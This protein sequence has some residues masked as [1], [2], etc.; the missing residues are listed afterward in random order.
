MYCVALEGRYLTS[1]QRIEVERRDT[2]LTDEIIIGTGKTRTKILSGVETPYDELLVSE[3]PRVQ[4]Y[5]DLI[6]IRIAL[7]AGSIPLSDAYTAVK[8]IE[9]DPEFVVGNTFGPLPEIWTP[10]MIS[11]L[12]TNIRI[13]QKSRVIEASNAYSAIIHT[14]KSASPQVAPEGFL[15]KVFSYFVYNPLAS[16]TQAGQD[17]QCHRSTAKS[18]FDKVNKKWRIMALSLLNGCHFGIKG[19]TLF[20]EMQDQTEWESIRDPLLSYPFV[21]T[22]HRGVT[23]PFGFV[24]FALPGSKRNEV[25]FRSSIARVAKRYF[26]YSSLHL[27][28]GLTRIVNPGLIKDGGWELPE[29]LISGEIRGP[30]K[31]KPAISSIGCP[32]YLDEL[33]K[34]DFITSEIVSYHLRKS[35]SELAEIMRSRGYNVNS[36]QIG[37]RIQKMMQ[38]GVMNPWLWFSGVGLHYSFTIEIVSNHEARQRIFEAVSGFPEVFTT[39]TDRGAIIW[40]D[41][42]K[43]HLKNYYDYLSLLLKIPGVERIRPILALERSGGKNYIDIYENLEFGTDGFCSTSSDMDINDYVP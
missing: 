20:F 42:P 41:I 6:K 14:L 35:N 34:D 43:Y 9:D 19:F 39:P 25:R 5:L 29:C 16:F 17:L 3:N 13:L 8:L 15:E 1:N 21:K 40:L 18:G 28:Q 23:S 22:L 37:Y 30:V 24:S 38:L 12:I 31:S 4:Y 2:Y 27:S 11:K 32:G 7:S 10:E 36:N 33:T 26:D